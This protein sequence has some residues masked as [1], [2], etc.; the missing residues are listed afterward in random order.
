MWHK[1]AV[2]VLTG[3]RNVC[4]VYHGK[5]ISGGMYNISAL[6]NFFFLRYQ[7]SALVKGTVFN[8]YTVESDECCRVLYMQFSFSSQARPIFPFQTRSWFFTLH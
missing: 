4:T 7:R 6:I 2:D 1:E 5:A 3:V 8:S